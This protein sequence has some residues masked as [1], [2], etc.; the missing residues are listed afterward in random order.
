MTLEAQVQVILEIMLAAFLSTIIGWDRESR[1]QPAGLRTHI[2]VAVGACL[3]TGLSVHA[4]QGDTGRV[5]AQI[6]T[7]IGFLGAGTIIQKGGQAHHLTTAASIWSTAAVGM[8]VGVGAWLVSIGATVI[9]WSVLVIMRR[10]KKEDNIIPDKEQIAK[11][12]AKGEDNMDD[13][14]VND[15]NR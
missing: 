2:L 12:E 8:A 13:R 6:V 9:I 4:F 5:A 11:E 3:F 15:Y 7:G 1:R 10:L 14:V